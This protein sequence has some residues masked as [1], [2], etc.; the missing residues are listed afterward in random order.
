MNRSFFE[1]Q[2]YDVGRFKT[3]LLK[4]QQRRWSNYDDAQAY[5]ILS[6]A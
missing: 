6:W 1:D 2:V 3:L 5:M 4:I